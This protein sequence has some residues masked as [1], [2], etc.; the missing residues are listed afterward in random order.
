MVRRLSDLAAVVLVWLIV[1]AVGD[2]RGYGAAADRDQAA[3]L[4][5]SIRGY[6]NRTPDLAGALVIDQ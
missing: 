2:A 4:I 3:L 6:A 1:Q 5:D